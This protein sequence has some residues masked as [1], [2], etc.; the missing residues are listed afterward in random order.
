MRIEQFQPPS[1]KPAAG[2]QPTDQ[3]TQA[4]GQLPAGAHADQVALS[5][6]S[7]ILLGG[8]EDDARLEQLRV[9]VAEGAYQ[10][11]AADLS[12]RLVDFHLSG[13]D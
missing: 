9:Q 10:V 6:L 1:V 5:R 3:P 2:T 12:Q 13:K 4:E 11:P 8:V 7:Q